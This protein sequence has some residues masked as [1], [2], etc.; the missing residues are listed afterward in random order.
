VKSIIPV[1][2]SLTP[3]ALY[4]GV[5]TLTASILARNRSIL[6]RF[7]LPPVFLFIS[8]NQFLPKTSRNLASYFSSLERAHAP[9]LADAHEQLNQSIVSTSEAAR[10]AWIRARNRSVGGVERTVTELQGRTGLKL[11]DALGWSE[12]AVGKTEVDVKVIAN[13]VENNVDDLAK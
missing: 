13:R 12:G 8:M 4:A 1:D 10:D 2:E 7:S 5:A 6:L 9:A 11:R 3:G